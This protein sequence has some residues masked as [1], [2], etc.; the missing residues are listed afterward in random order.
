MNTLHVREEV[1][2]PA[3]VR[4]LFSNALMADGFRTV[5]DFAEHNGSDVQVAFTDALWGRT[6][7]NMK[8]VSR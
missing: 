8:E 6:A 7:L 2:S 1:F 4:R 5:V 3:E